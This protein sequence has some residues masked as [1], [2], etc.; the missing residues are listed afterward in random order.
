[1][2]QRHVA[3]RE[4]ATWRFINQL[5]LDTCQRLIGP[6]VCH[7]NRRTATCLSAMLP[8]VPAVQPSH[9]P[10]QLPYNPVTCHVTCHTTTCCATS[11]SVLHSHP[12]TSASVQSNCRL[13][14]HVSA[15]YWATSCTDYHVSSVQCHMSNPYSANSA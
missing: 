9:L 2:M 12:A 8:R 10:R 5:K 3:P 15:C 6:R 4:W 11:S 14:F 1:M 7:V 13:Y